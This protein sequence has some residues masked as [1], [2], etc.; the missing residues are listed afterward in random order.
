MSLEEK[1]FFLT[2][3]L[4]AYDQRCHKN[5]LEM[6][7]KFTVRQLLELWIP[8]D[9]PYHSATVRIHRYLGLTG[10]AEKIMKPLEENIE[11]MIHGYQLIKG[12]ESNYEVWLEQYNRV[13]NDSLS[14]WLKNWVDAVFLF[15]HK[16]YSQA[17]ENMRSAFETIRYTAAN[18]MI[19]FLESY[20]IISL[21]VDNKRGWKDFKRAFKWGVFMN[22]FGDLKPF[23]LVSEETEIRS[24]FEEKLIVIS[25]F[26][27]I[28]DLKTLAKL[29]FHF[30]YSST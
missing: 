25:K 26:E 11:N 23:Y 24:I 5:L 18:K 4:I 12:S 19:E 14:P 27:N 3:L 30:P 8:K 17:L 29:V 22:N 1:E 16:E 9:K 13:N 10:K 20:M 6:Q 28:R 21:L 7:E 2:E 15:E